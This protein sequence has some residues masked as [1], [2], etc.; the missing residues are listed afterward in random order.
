M[1]KG[2]K[3]GLFGGSFNPAHGGHR[4]MS[5]G[6]LR[7]LR[8]NEIW[9]L[10]SPQ[11][12]LKPR[13]GMAPMAIR[14]AQARRVARHPRI[15]PTTIEADMGTAR[16]VDTLT[17]LVRRFPQARFLWLMGSDNLV[18]FHRWASW[19]TIA[20]TVPIV[21][22]DRSPHI[23]KSR[24]APAMG[25]LRQHVRRHPARWAEWRAPAIGFL[26]LGLDRRSAT[27]IRRADPHWATRIPDGRTFRDDRP[28]IGTTATGTISIDTTAT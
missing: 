15:V 25:W 8:L 9:W 14:L 17:G 24:R 27:G 16:T 7:R 22:V 11:N 23:G 19:R 4:H 26:H 28:A 6:A 2:W 3:V 12:P 1:K 10:V 5:L 21:V 20:R 13:A 18:Q